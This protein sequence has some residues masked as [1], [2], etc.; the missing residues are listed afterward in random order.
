MVMK[1]RT[2][3][4]RWAIYRIHYGNDF[5]KQ[6]IDSIKHYV[7]KVFVLYSLK[8]W[9]VKDTVNYLGQE[10]PMPPLH[11]DV[12]QFLYDNYGHRQ[13]V[14]Y[15]QAEVSTPLN[16]FR[17]YYDVCVKLMKHEP[18]T[19]LFMEP[20]MVFYR[21]AV[22][23]L[24]R[25]LEYRT[26]IPCI[27]TTQIELWKNEEYRVPQRDRIGPMIWKPSRDRNFKTHFGTWH[28]DRKY[29]SSTIQNYNF[30]FCLNAQTMF[31]KHLTAIN[32]SAAIGDSI[33][34]QEWYRDKW[35][36]WTPLTEDLEISANYKHTIPKAVPYE[37]DPV[38]IEQMRKSV[39]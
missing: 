22:E 20:D 5:L 1:K 8:P 18:D 27:G 16:Q 38:V 37:M 12:Q 17:H 24:Y 26:D 2:D 23:T 4:K 33:P 25:E 34:S 3:P 29:V 13:R 39:P 6:S 21:P 19:V 10:I 35:L 7:D 36:N 32:F 14:E 31:Y 9:V 30:G 15:F 28:P 11:E